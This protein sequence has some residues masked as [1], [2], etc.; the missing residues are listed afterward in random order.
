[1]LLAPSMIGFA[2]LQSAVLMGCTLQT[3]DTF[4]LGTQ[5]QH[6]HIQQQQLQR[7]RQDAT[8]RFNRPLFAAAKRAT[9]GRRPGQDDRIASSDEWEPTPCQPDEARLT[10]IQITD[11]YTL[12]HLASVKTLLEETRAR[13]TGSNVICVIT[14]DFLSPYLLSSVDRGQGMMNALNKIPMVRYVDRCL[15]I[16]TSWT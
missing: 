2:V 14:G 10:V 12:E 4:Q 7:S 8:T 6:Q 15:S 5:H 3:V 1:M 9:G 13:S 16:I 11:V